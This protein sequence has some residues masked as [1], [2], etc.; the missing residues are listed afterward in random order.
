MIRLRQGQFSQVR[1]K[2]LRPSRPIIWC[3]FCLW[4]SAS[5]IFEVVGLGL[6]SRAPTQNQNSI[7]YF[8]TRLLKRYWFWSTSTHKFFWRTSLRRSADQHNART[9]SNIFF[10]S[11][12]PVLYTAISKNTHCARK[13][14]TPHLRAS[15]CCSS[16]NGRVT[17]VVPPYEGSF[18]AAG[19]FLFSLLP[20]LSY[21]IQTHIYSS[22]VQVLRLRRSFL[23]LKDV[24]LS[25]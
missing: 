19:H 12:K 6:T 9:H 16:L 4:G 1:C 3:A 5:T 17:P 24:R 14:Y 23:S 7:Y 25:R 11:W 15:K 2:A 21:I 18:T 10:F 20:S 8:Q 22:C 13:Y